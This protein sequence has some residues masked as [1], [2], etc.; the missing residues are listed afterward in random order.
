MMVM[1]YHSYWKPHP[2]PTTSALSLSPPPRY[3]PD[4]RADG[5]EEEKK[6]SDWWRTLADTVRWQVTP[7]VPGNNTWSTI[8][9]AC[10]LTQKSYSPR[11]AGLI[12]SLAGPDLD[13]ALDTLKVLPAYAD[14]V[15]LASSASHWR[16]VC[17]RVVVVLAT[18]GIVAP[19][20]VAWA[21]EQA[22]SSLAEKYVLSN[23]VRTYSKTSST[24]WLARNKAMFAFQEKSFGEPVDPILVDDE[25][26]DKQ[27]GASAIEVPISPT[28]S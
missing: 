5:H 10:Y 18:Q 22:S 23:A 2:D 16:D 17:L 28:I 27:E 25:D 11:L 26:A 19:G 8:I 20:A 4:F 24:V 3:R 9:S 7:P 13:R 15:D 14:M 6:E 12:G 21:F 1:K